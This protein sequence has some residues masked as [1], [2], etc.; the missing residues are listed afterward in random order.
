MSLDPQGQ[1]ARGSRILGEFSVSSAPGNEREAAERVAAMV[2]QADTRPRSVDYPIGFPPARLE[3]LKTA[4]AE[5]VLNAMEHG[6]R[7]RP[8]LSV[9][10]RVIVSG[11]ALVVR[12]ADQGVGGPRL[13]LKSAQARAPDL[14]A[15]L[16]GEQ[17]PRG[18]GLYLIAQMADDV[19][20]LNCEGENIV[21]LLWNLDEVSGNAGP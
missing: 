21:E 17:P 5:A 8:D 1:P 18:W 12:I 7:Y 15:K 3:E 14:T 2:R 6:N 10:V 13:H 16:A 20:I 19:R 4:V 9:R 11:K